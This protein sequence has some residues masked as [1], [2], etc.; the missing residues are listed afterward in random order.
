MSSPL[1]QVSI[2]GVNEMDKQ[3]FVSFLGGVYE[4]SEWIAAQ[5]FEDH[6]D[7][8]VHNFRSVDHVVQIFMDFVEKH[9]RP[10]EDRTLRLIREHPE[11]A[12]RDPSS[13][14]DDSRREQRGAGLSLDSLSGEQ[15]K[16][17][18]EYNTLYKQ[19]FAMPFV[20]CV[21]NHPDKALGILRAFESRIDNDLRTEVN[22]ALDEIKAIAEYRLRDRLIDNNDDGNNG[23]GGRTHKSRL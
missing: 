8:K 18:G 22:S 21:R 20:T 16:R 19:R 14:S 23:G 17:F 12:I 3:Q 10:Y 2:H 7:G 4:H 1:Q 15:Q 11:L 6:F 5:I 9:V 13:L